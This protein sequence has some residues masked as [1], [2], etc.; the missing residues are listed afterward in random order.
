VLGS[1]T[2][3][4]CSRRTGLQSLPGNRGPIQLD[5]DAGAPEGDGHEARVLPACQM[6]ARLVEPDVAVAHVIATNIRAS[7]HES[8]VGSEEQRL[9]RDP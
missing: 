9:G 1:R 5:A 8:G 3:M 4:S 6:A 2:T 7:A